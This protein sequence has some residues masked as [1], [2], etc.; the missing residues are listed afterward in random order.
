MLLDI[1]DFG[2]KGVFSSTNIFSEEDF[3]KK[4]TQDLLRK[5]W[6]EI[7]YVHDDYDIHD[8]NY[9]LKAVGLP[10][11]SFFSS[12]SFGFVIGDDIEILEF[13]KDGKKEEYDYSDYSLEFKI[14]L[15]NNESNRIHIKYKESPS[16][17]KMTEGEKRERKF[18]RNDYYG[19]SK[20]IAGQRAKFVLCIK[21]D[22]EI[23]GFEKGF[24]AKIKD[25]QNEYRWAGKV[26]DDGKKI[27]VKMSRKTAKFDFNIIEGIESIEKKPLKNTTLSFNSYFMG[28][29]LEIS[30]LKIYSNQTKQIEHDS[31]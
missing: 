17:R 10:S 4:G 13:E 18:V 29:N 22:F 30:N 11:N 27:L 7:C 25:K 26:P 24:L 20:N 14:C 19:I 15:K 16:K 3:V 31:L 28:G 9:E 1:S 23:I 2:K 8:V 12:C 21:C 6:N 5:N